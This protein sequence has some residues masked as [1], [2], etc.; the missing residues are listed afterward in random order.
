M[1]GVFRRA[2]ISETSCPEMLVFGKSWQIG[3]LDVFL[4]ENSDKSHNLTN[5]IFMTSSLE[6][7]I[8]SSIGISISINISVSVSASMSVCVSISIYHPC[9]TYLSRGKVASTN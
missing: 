9:L 7:C 1:Y 8:G 4:L 3:L 6:N 5:L 2:N